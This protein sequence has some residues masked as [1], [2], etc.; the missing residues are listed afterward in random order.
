LPLLFFWLAGC[1]YQMGNLLPQGIHTVA[2]PVFGNDTLYRGYEFSLTEAVIAEILNLTSLQIATVAR[3]DTLLDASIERIAQSTIAK[4]ENRLATR[5]DITITVH[6]TW[7]DLRTGKNIVPAR[8]IAETVEINTTQGETL[9]NAIGQGLRKLAR[10]IVY[11][12]EDPYWVPGA[13]ATPTS[14]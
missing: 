6:I 8:K 14:S 13:A 9:D 11:A 1:G 7:R 10:L 5:L 12:L 3:A 4:D 2:V